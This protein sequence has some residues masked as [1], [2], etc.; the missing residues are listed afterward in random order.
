MNILHEHLS[1]SFQ[2][3]SLISDTTFISENL[4]SKGEEEILSFVGK[5]KG[6]WSII[7]YQENTKRLYFGRDVFGRHSLLWNL[8]SAALPMFMVTSV[9]QQKDGVQ[10]IPAYGLYC[11]D[12]SLC[13]IAEE[14]Q[15]NL[16]PWSHLNNESLIPVSLNS[17]IKI[18]EQRIVSSISNTLNMSLPSECVENYL[19]S[20]PT[21]I[22]EENLGTL[23]TTMKDDVDKLLENM[24]RSVQRRAIKSPPKC[25]NCTASP[26]ECSH[27]RIAVL[28]SGGLDSAMI[29]LLL[30]SYIPESES[31]DLLNVAFAQKVSQN[32]Q[33]T[34]KHKMKHKAE[35][36][37]DS[38]MNYEV[39]DRISG[40]QCWEQLQELKPDRKWNFVEVSS[41]Y[42]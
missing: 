42:V 18:R 22:S 28:F 41:K 31:I 6:P 24:K 20:L 4:A 5:I 21:S 40:R 35:C 34:K 17:V 23:Y 14:F 2:I 29:A 16:F 12:F 39:P 25:R 37:I 26:E 13:S 33:S 1:I 30:N 7:F 11:I 32:S 38:S 27:S 15:I 10:E 36:I 8:P 3:P 9:S 19:N